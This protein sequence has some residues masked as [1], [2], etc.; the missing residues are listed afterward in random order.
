MRYL[1]T[2]AVGAL[3]LVLTADAVRA[4]ERSRYREFELGASVS[5]IAALSGAAPSDI[6]TIHERPALLQEL[7]W[8]PSYF[9]GSTTD[10]QT[11]PIRQILFSFYNDQLF[12]IVVEYDRQRTEGLTEGDIVEGIADVYGAPAKPAPKSDA[13]LSQGERESGTAVAAWRDAEHEIVLYRAS[14]APA[15]KLF[16]TARRLDALART[17]EA[18]SVRLAEREAPQRELVRKAKEADD[19]RASQEKARSANKAAFRP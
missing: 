3:L 5:T 14:Y 2:L 10:L 18:Q 12:R 16:V 15:F 13:A 19:A 9:I 1:K 8:R 7:L 11:D 17:A 6:K 4:Q